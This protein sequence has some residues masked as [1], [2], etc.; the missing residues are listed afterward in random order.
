MWADGIE[1]GTVTVGPINW[2]GVEMRRWSLFTLGVVS[3]TALAGCA[4]GDGAGV[5]NIYSH[6]HYEADEQLFRRF[7]EET[8]IRVNVVTASADELI[9]RLEHEGVNSPADLLITVDAGR[10][11]RAK[12]KGLLQPVRSDLL[13]ESIPSSL[14]DPEGY[15]YGLTKRARV[16]VY[17]TTRVRAGEL[18][19]YEDLVDPRW[20]GRVL[21]RSSG[22]VYNQSLL[23][24]IVA[25]VG[26]EAA[27]AWAA[28]VVDN[29]ARQPSG[30]DTDQAKAV[31]A[32]VGD[33]AIVNSYYI[34]R[35]KA[36]ADQEER[37]IGE[38]LAVV[39]PN[40]SGR[41]T[42]I[43]VSGA[44]VTLSSKNRANAV[45]LMEFLASEAAQRVFSE[46]I[47][48]YPVNPRVEPAALL[49]EWGEFRADTLN[50][51][52]LGELNAPAVKV[53]DRVG[54]R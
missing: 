48:E 47:Y 34:A 50:L 20:R 9:T 45:R 5:V 21:V 26:E 36:S 38:R 6:R 25:T 7:T 39:F 14:R 27:S 40:Q 33:V 15:W 16:L 1:P 51:A 54:W 32:G 31:A 18:S 30:S 10:L 42:H 46:T 35:L 29:M 19:S 8:G 23:A 24:S 4:A 49:R 44:G 28:G 13:E 52:R 43:N 53:F 37:R 2:D 11:H 12:E 22:N 41:G 17:D 3:L